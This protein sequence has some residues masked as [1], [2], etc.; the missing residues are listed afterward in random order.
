MAKNIVF[1]DIVNDTNGFSKYIH[2]NR[3]LNIQ[4]LKIEGDDK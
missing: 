1:T 4:E 3:E 2:N